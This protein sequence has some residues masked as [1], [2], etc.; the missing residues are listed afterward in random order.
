MRLTA[1]RTSGIDYGW[2]LTGTL[3]VT[4]TASYGV[5]L[6]AFPVMIG[7]MQAELGWSTTLLT[8]GFS[9]AALASGLAAIPIGRALDHHGPRIVMSAGSV[10]A[11]ALLLAWSRV[12]DPVAYVLVWMGLGAC[13]AAVFYEPAFAVVTQWFST[14]R[15]RARAFAVITL[16]GGLAS[17]LFVPLA[18]TLVLDIGWRGAIL[19]LAATLGLL[20]ILPHALLLRSPPG[21]RVGRDDAPRPP[22]SPPAAS[23]ATGRILRTPVFRWIALAL[24]LATVAN[25]AIAVHLVPLLLERG[26]AATTAASAL[27]LLG[28]AKLPGRALLAP[29]VARTSARTALLCVLA[30]QAAALAAFCTPGGS[31]PWIFIALFGAGDGAGTPARAEL[32][33]ELFDT[34][35]YG[36]ISGV[37]AF[38]L[39]LARATAPVGASLA[40][41]WLG[42]Y[43]AVLWLLLGVTVAAAGAMTAASFRGAARLPVRHSHRFPDQDQIMTSNAT[44]AAPDLLEET[45]RI[46]GGS[47]KASAAPS[48]CCSSAKQE[49]CCEPSEKADCCGTAAAS[50]AGGC[51]CQ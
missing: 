6:Y 4:V 30:L 43:D 10:L 21:Q 2:V 5:L 18:S 3:A 41:S 40:W 51:G 9:A 31:S 19:W 16:A 34:A 49:V 14:R 15:E 26:Y 46:L 8:G 29:L 11:V 20:T 35:E 45:R 42:G 37:L 28:L 12:H 27:A 50:S 38:I 39:S 36:R 33:A 47:V 32:L 22:A 1:A 48:T 24:F 23:P 17:T 25:F 44:T 13:T 7:P